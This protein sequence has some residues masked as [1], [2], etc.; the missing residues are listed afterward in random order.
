MERFDRELSRKP[1]GH[2]ESLVRILNP[3][4]EMYSI[5]EKNGEEVASCPSAQESWMLKWWKKDGWKVWKD[6]K[7]LESKEAAP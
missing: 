2:G 5:I 7:K 6:I 1:M 4:G 3:A